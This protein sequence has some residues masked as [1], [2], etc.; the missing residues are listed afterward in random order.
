MTEEEIKIGEQWV[1][2]L[3]KYSKDFS[4]KSLFNSTTSFLKVKSSGKEKK[5]T[6][7]KDIG[8]LATAKPSAEE[9]EKISLMEAAKK[10]KALD[11]EPTNLFLSI[12]PLFFPLVF[13]RNKIAVFHKVFLLYFY[14]LCI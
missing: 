3:A 2:I 14:Y 6:L 4:S 11:E 5:F 10:R 12:Y 13:R 1:G 8:K 9:L 7:S